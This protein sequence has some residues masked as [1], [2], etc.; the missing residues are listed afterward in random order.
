MST[1]LKQS[2]SSSRQHYSSSGS[3][4]SLFSI[5]S[6]RWIRLLLLAI[7]LYLAFLPLWW[8]SLD[9]LAHVTGLLAN[10]IY[11][12]LDPRVSIVPDGK[13]V[14]ISVA[15]S[16]LRGPQPNS[17]AL[18][19]DTVTYGFPMLAALVVVTHADSMRAKIRS[20]LVGLGVMV[21]LTVPVVMA[22]AKLTS[23]E[24]DEL[25]TR[26]EDRS[27]MLFDIMHGYAFSQPVVA[28]VVWWL[29]ITLGLFKEGQSQKT[30]SVAVTRNAP[31]PCGSGRKY[32][33]C[34]GRDS[35]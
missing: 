8:Y 22:T 28:V 1:L 7:V 3:I 16:Q 26:G 5:G 15:A 14:R 10:W 29:L 30:P 24:V 13:V 4:D 19:L 34:C 23:M 27:G 31:C 21:V 9:I 12:L 17:S 20:L 25:I 35:S 2:S 32:K 6:R 18:R 33:R 11:S